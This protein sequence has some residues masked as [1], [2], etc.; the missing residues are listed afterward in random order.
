M[1]N[2]NQPIGLFGG[3]FDPIHHGHLRTALEL[4]QALNLKEVRMI[5]CYLPVHR[6]LP[7]ATHEHR[8][9]MLECAVKSEPALVV[10][11]CE[12]NRKSPSYTIDTVKE[13]RE[14]YPTTPLCF[15]MGIDAMLGFTSWDDWEIILQK[16]HLIIAH[17]PNYQLPK[18]GIIADLLKERLKKHP[19]AISD[20]VAGNIIL[21]PVTA[22]EIS[23]TDIR[24]Q[25]ASGK[26]PRYLLPDSVYDYILENGV[27]SLNR[28]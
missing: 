13:L 25:I 4:Y 23:A 27:Y 18:T 9:A 15:I 8:V 14:Q 24:K 20:S 7:N 10:D 19:E 6:K 12:I 1:Q 3:T 11:Y 21:Q 5:P 17:R 2:K 28:I 16:V 22:L 26:N